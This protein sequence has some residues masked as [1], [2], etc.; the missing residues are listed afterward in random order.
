M[1]FS[2]RARNCCRT[3]VVGH[4]ADK[5]QI[6][7]AVFLNPVDVLRR[8]CVYSKVLRQAAM[9][10]KGNDAWKLALYPSHRFS[11]LSLPSNTNR[12]FRSRICSGPPLSPWKTSYTLKCNYKIW[13]TWQESIPPVKYPAQKAFVIS[14]PLLPVLL[15]ISKQ[16]ESG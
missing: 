4:R 6:S 15:I 11:V 7:L 2:V 9:E 3:F 13:F 12:P 14:L 1:R 5:I 16:V 8:V 10:P